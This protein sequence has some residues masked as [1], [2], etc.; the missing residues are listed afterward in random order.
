MAAEKR[1]QA[2]QDR[3]KWVAED[4]CDLREYIASSKKCDLS[5]MSHVT[6]IRQCASPKDTD[7]SCVQINIL[8]LIFHILESL[9]ALKYSAVLQFWKKQ[10]KIH[11]L[12]M[13]VYDTHT[14]P[15]MGLQTSTSEWDSNSS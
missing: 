4:D 6:S 10:M 7:K 2:L 8:S 14:Q 5:L 15:C 3:L 13:S 12:Q 11:Q 9:Q 1:S